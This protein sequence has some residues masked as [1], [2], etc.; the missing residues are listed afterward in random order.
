MMFP[1]PPNLQIKF[2]GCTQVFSVRHR[3]RYIIV[4]L[5]ISRHNKVHDEIIYLAWKSF[6]SH[7]VHGEPLIHQ[8]RSRSEEE[9]HQGEGGFETRG[10]VL[11]QGLREIQTDTIID[12]RFGDSYADTYNH[13]SMDKVLSSW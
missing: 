1:P 3:L 13:E 7:C 12:V 9:V 5:A 2:N 10:D 8:G 11:I 4:G 6:P